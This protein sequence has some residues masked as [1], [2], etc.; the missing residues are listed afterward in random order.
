M[1]GDS[2]PRFEFHFSYDSSRD[3]DFENFRFVCR[4]QTSFLCVPLICGDFVDFVYSDA[5]GHL[6]ICVDIERNDYE[7]KTMWEIQKKTDGMLEKVLEGIYV[8][9]E[10]RSFRLLG[11]INLVYPEILFMYRKKCFPVR[12]G[13]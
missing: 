9:Y 12:R 6:A 11:L 10:V 2:L 5:F 8:T 13:L 1:H 3:Q 7:A 4:Q